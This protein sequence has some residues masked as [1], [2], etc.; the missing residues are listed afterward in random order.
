M[1]HIPYCQRSIF[2]HTISVSLVWEFAVYIVS[3]YW[4]TFP[5]YTLHVTFWRHVFMSRHAFVVMLTVSINSFKFKEGACS[6][7]HM[8]G[9]DGYLISNVF[10]VISIYDYIP[11]QPMSFIQGMQWHFCVFVPNGSFLLGF[12]VEPCPDSVGT[13][14]HIVI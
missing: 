11:T 6:I 8:K 7:V 4:R 1:H 12:L 13:I 9:H 3:Y 14:P 10:L 5:E 2:I